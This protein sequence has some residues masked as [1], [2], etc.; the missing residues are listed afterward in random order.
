MLDEVAPDVFAFS[1]VAEAVPVADEEPVPGFYDSVVLTSVPVPTPVLPAPVSAAPVFDDSVVLS[2][3]PSGE[4][5]VDVESA[6]AIPGEVATIRPM[7][8][9]AANAPTRPMC[10]L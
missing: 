6:L 4:V 8:N 7:P 5:A 3:P 1:V 2:V 9:A 10:R